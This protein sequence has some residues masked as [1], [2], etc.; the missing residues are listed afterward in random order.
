[1]IN[2]VD[3]QLKVIYPLNYTE[4]QVQG[5][6]QELRARDFSKLNSLTL[7]TEDVAMS[8]VFYFKELLEK[9]L[10]LVIYVR[11]NVYNMLIEN[12]EDTFK[13]NRLQIKGK[14]E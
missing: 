3:N 14:N 4:E 12:F 13:S 1:M 9:E 11:E 6:I 2:T 7:D 10:D 5:L 8:I